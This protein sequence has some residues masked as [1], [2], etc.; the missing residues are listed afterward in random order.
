MK[1]KFLA[2][3]VDRVRPLA[4]LTTLWL[5]VLRA[6]HSAM[7]VCR[8]SLVMIVFWSGLN[9]NLK[10]CREFKQMPV[11]DCW[12]EEIMLL[13]IDK[14]LNFLTSYWTIHVYQ[15]FFKN[16]SKQ[17]PKCIRK[18]LGWMLPKRKL[19]FKKLRD[20]LE[21]I[22]DCFQMFLLLYR[23]EH[24]TMQTEWATKSWAAC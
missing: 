10:L 1:I 5:E 6:N 22:W 11:K 14:K 20:S 9:K 23:G 2:N 19:D 18:C 21:W 17:L 12:L 24:P 7:L 4:W 15:I 16:K 13:I 3:V 8:Y